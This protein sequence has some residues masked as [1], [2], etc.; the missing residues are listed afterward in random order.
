MP[1][2][3]SLLQ[4]LWTAGPVTLLG[5]WG[6]YLLGYGKAPTAENYIFFIS[7]TVITGAA[8]IIANLAHNLA[9]GRKAER[10]AL[11]IE[12]VISSLPELL[13]VT[14]NLIV[15]SLE[16]DARRREAAAMLL[17]KQ[18]LSPEGV[19]L[20]AIELLDD[21]DSARV[22]AQIEIYRR[23]GLQ[24]RIRDLMGLYQDTLDPSLPS[25]PK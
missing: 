3:V 6:G 18:D 9:G 23:V 2:T 15:E 4:I 24:A 5:A 19:E 13:L 7:Y 1:W 12:R 17:R 11:K 16:G 25:W 14:R 10:T 21:R 20:A 8:G 22:I